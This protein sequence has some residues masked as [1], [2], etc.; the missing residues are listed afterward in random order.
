V[1]GGVERVRLLDERGDAASGRARMLVDRPG[2]LV[3]MVEAPGRRLL[4][5]TERAHDG[6]SATIAGAPL[7]MERVEGDFL[8]CV[9]DAGTHAVELRFMP[10]SF[11]YGAIVSGIGLVLLAAV[12]VAGLWRALGV[13]RP[14]PAVG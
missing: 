11:V 9:V 13:T 5:F 7:R 12:S 14:G 2:R 8:A 6:W 1:E 3:V 4:A 10:R